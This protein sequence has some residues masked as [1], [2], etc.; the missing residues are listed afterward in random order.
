MFV[1]ADK[2]TKVIV[3][4]GTKVVRDQFANA[5]RVT[6]SY[7]ESTEP[8]DQRF[9]GPEHAVWTTRS[10]HMVFSWIDDRTIHTR[11]RGIRV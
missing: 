2:E 10:N 7:S 1:Y 11:Q 4:S 5:R 3:G 8:A 9:A 6:T